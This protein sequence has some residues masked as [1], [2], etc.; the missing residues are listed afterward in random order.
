MEQRRNPRPPSPSSAAASRS[1]PSANT[2]GRDCTPATTPNAAPQARRPKLLDQVRQALRT[3]H[4]SLRTEKAYVA[5]IRRF[6]LFHGKRHPA[7]MGATEIAEFLSHLALERAVSASTQ[8]QA[9]SAILFLYQEVLR[10]KLAQIDEVVRARAPRRRPTVLT[11]SEVRAV[12]DRLTG[13]ARIRATLLYGAGL[14][15][16]ECLRLRVK[17]VDLERHE[18]LV[19]SG[20][21][22]KDR[23]TMFPEALVPAFREHLARL[24]VRHEAELARGAGRVSLPNAIAR[25]YPNASR[26]WAWQFVFPASKLCR[27]PLTGDLV[28]H[29]LHETVLQREVRTAVKAAALT[30][31]ATCHS[32]RHSFATHLLEDG[33][34]IR[35]V[36]ELLGHRDVTTT[37]IYTHVLN[38]GGL[39]VRSPA[40]KL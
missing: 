28:R 18:I 36:Q 17:D 32:L 14:R 8:N 1:E 25:K 38:R 31:P 13:A 34:D 27:D 29:H 9:F 4:R 6:I 2:D 16:T 20:K 33:Y 30:K 3:L 11:R 5:W 40:D 19:R 39:G 23:T 7:A 22:D 15:V 10:I 26:E 21:G 12:L 37:M 35:T 24:R